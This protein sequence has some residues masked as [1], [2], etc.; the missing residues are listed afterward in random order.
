MSTMNNHRQRLATL[1][2]Q[3][4]ATTLISTFIMTSGQEDADR[5]VRQFKALH[6]DRS[7]TLFVMVGPTACVAR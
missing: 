3:A 5:Q 2:Q 6:P 1:E 4:D 7:M